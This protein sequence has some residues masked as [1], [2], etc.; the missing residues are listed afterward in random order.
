MDEEVQDGKVIAS[1]LYKFK[2][3]NTDLIKDLTSKDKKSK[4]KL[5][6]KVTI[7]KEKLIDNML[8]LGM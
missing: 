7:F 3:Q 1:R 5:K 4:L 8:G 2:D 6:R